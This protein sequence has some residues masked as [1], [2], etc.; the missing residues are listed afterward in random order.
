PAQRGP[1]AGTGEGRLRERGVADPLLAELLGQAEA[2]RERAAVARH[3]LAH[4]EDP[5]VALQGLPVRLAQRL[6]VGRLG[7]LAGAGGPRSGRRRGH[8][9]PGSLVTKRVRSS[10]GSSGAASAVSTAAEISAAIS[11][12]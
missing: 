2:D 1:D 10:T 7:G 6:P 9:V 4:E 11:P 8:G 3:V 12:S 5:R